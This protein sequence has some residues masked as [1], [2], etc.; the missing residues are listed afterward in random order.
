MTER[1]ARRLTKGKKGWKIGRV[2]AKGVACWKKFSLVDPTA[3]IQLNTWVKGIAV[4]FSS[5]FPFLAELLPA[6]DSH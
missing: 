6:D 4:V 5:C 2:V 1:K 3:L